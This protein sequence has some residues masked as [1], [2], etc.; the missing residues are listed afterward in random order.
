VGDILARAGCRYV[1]AAAR[2]AD[3]ELAR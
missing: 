2:S 3:R 1:A